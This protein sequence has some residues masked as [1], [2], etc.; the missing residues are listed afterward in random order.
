MDAAQLLERMKNVPAPSPMAHDVQAAFALRLAAIADKLTP[1]EL[2][3]F[4]EIGFVIG[5]RMTRKVP[6]LGSIG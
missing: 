3:S 6:V 5:S 2:E 1:E 4:I